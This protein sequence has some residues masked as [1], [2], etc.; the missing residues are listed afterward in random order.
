MVG[1]IAMLLALLMPAFARA[2]RQSR[3]LV[4]MS[5]L[6][7]LGMAFAIHVAEHKGQTLKAEGEVFDDGPLELEPLLVRDR[8]REDS[9]VMFCPEATE[10]G[11]QFQAG[12]YN[13]HLGTVDHCW[14]I[15][16]S[17]NPGP[18]PVYKSSSYGM[19]NWVSRIRS[20]GYGDRYGK[21]E[22]FIDPGAKRADSVPLFGDAVYPACIPMENDPPPSDLRVPVPDG[23]PLP[24]IGT[25]MRLFCIARHGRSINIVFLDGHAETVRLEDL[26]RLRWNSKFVP[27]SVTLPLY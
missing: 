26:W 24:L 27:R 8:Q 9:G 23:K 16:T 3:T 5:N 17:T 19:N 22:M 25:S 12:S 18:N 7:Q 11:P 13:F 20:L 2:R 1:I 21:G 6:R 15:P 10:F 14:A 4:C